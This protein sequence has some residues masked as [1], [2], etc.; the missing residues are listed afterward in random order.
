MQHISDPPPINDWLMFLSYDKSECCFVEDSIW[1]MFISYYHLFV[2][3]V[4]RFYK[5]S[6]VCENNRFLFEIVIRR[7]AEIKAENLLFQ[8][9]LTNEGIQCK[10]LFIPAEEVSNHFPAVGIPAAETHHME[11]LYFTDD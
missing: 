11:R 7:Y 1:Q 2:G 6:P 5:P 10:S 3:D 9:P 8:L 4:I